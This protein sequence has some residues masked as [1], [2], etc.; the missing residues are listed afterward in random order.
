[1]IQP[2]ILSPGT[3]VCVLSSP[4]SGGAS[5]L[6]TVVSVTGGKLRTVTVACA[7]GLLT[8]PATKVSTVHTPIAGR[9]PALGWFGRAA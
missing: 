2:A 9:T 4:E 3:Q 8:V 1:M 5:H 7:T 6:G